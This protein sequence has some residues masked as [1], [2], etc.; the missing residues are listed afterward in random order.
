MSLLVG[1]TVT[2]REQARTIGMLGARTATDRA[3][4][5]TRDAS[6]TSRAGAICFRHSSGAADTKRRSSRRFRLDRRMGNQHTSPERSILETVEAAAGQAPDG[7][8][9]GAFRKAR[10]A[11]DSYRS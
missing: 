2:P 6:L 11:S 9:L 4:V 8:P 5:L 1:V 10:T 7:A 3:H